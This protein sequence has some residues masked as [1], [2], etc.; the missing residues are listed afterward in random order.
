MV[1]WSGKRIE[2]VANR[3]A[4]LYGRGLR[5]TLSTTLQIAVVAPMPKASVRIATTANAGPFLRI[6]KP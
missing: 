4:F 6:R 2:G 3:S 1:I 5:R